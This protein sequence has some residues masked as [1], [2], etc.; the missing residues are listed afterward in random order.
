MRL[1]GSGGGGKSG[2]DAIT[3][4]SPNPFLEMI[5]TVL[6]GDWDVQLDV[7][8]AGEILSTSVVTFTIVIF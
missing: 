3:R 5:W 2:F 8:S 7:L 4:K 6:E 1:G